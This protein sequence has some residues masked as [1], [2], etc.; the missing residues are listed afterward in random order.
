LG[1]FLVGIGKS[2]MLNLELGR[3]ST[4]HKWTPSFWFYWWNFAKKKEI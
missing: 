3:D 2:R 1:N 4:M